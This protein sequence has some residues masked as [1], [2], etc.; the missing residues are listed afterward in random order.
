M[1][2]E[3]T[4]KTPLYN[5]LSEQG[6][7]IYLPQGI[8]HWSGRAKKEAEISGTLGSAFGYEKDFIEGGSSD[9]LPLYLEDI[10]KY[11][12]LSVKEVVPYSQVSGLEEL[13][14]HWKKWL[15][16]KSGPRGTKN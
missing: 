7:R 12:T 16:K 14:T 9:W 6:K 2:F 1:E 5:A 3:V 4:K 13:K 15:I 10:K 8:F 11:T